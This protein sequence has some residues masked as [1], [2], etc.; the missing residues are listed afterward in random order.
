MRADTTGRA[1]AKL[2][3]VKAGDVLELDA[4]FDCVASGPVTVEENDGRLFFQCSRG[5]H[6]LE[7]QAEETDDLIGVYFA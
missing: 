6:Y 2:S 5:H 3:E 7:G 4:G 1:Y